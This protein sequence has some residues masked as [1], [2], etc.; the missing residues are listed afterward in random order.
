[1]R[2][3]MDEQQVSDASHSST[4][5]LPAKNP[6]FDT[7]YPGFSQ[8]QHEGERLIIDHDQLLDHSIFPGQN[9]SLDDNQAIDLDAYGL[10]DDAW[11]TQ[12]FI[13]SD[14]LEIARDQGGFFF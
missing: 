3:P 4:N 10:S 13:D 14:W 11:F 8:E 6:N 1:M 12:N 2:R 7:N 5:P 9:I